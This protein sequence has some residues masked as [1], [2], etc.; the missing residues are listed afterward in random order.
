MKFQINQFK[1]KTFNELP[2]NL[3]K[4]STVGAIMASIAK[5]DPRV[6]IPSITMNLFVRRYG[7]VKL[8]D[9]PS[10]VLKDVKNGVLYVKSVPNKLLESGKE[11]GKT[12]SDAGKIIG[13]RLQQAIT[14]LVADKSL[15]DTIDE[16]HNSE[17]KKL[18][19]DIT[20][21][22]KAIWNDPSW[23]DPTGDTTLLRNVYYNT[24]PLNTLS[25]TIS[26]GLNSITE[27]ESMSL[28]A[29][30][31][32]RLIQDFFISLGS[33]VPSGFT[34]SKI[35]EYVIKSA[36]LYGLVLWLHKSQNCKNV[37]FN[38]RNYSKLLTGSWTR[39]PLAGIY[40]ETDESLNHDTMWIRGG[41]NI[42]LPVVEDHESWSQFNNI[43]NAQWADMIQ[44]VRSVVY[45]PTPIASLLKHLLTT[46][47]A[48]FDDER[49]NELV[50]FVPFSFDSRQTT[51]TV[52]DKITSAYNTLSQYITNY[53][54]LVPIL[55]LLGWQQPLA[56]EDYTRDLH[57]TTFTIS[58]DPLLLT[59]LL[60]TP[61]IYQQNKF[62][63]EEQ[64]TENDNYLT[65]KAQ[66][67]LFNEEVSQTLALG[68]I[69]EF[70]KFVL[71]GD[72]VRLINVIIYQN[73]IDS[74]DVKTAFRNAV[75]YQ[76]LKTSYPSEEDVLPLFSNDDALRNICK[77]FA[78]ASYDHDP[79]LP[80]YFKVYQSITEIDTSGAPETGAHKFR[81]YAKRAWEGDVFVIPD[82]EYLATKLRSY[83]WSGMTDYQI[84]HL[85]SLIVPSRLSTSKV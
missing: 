58:R 5:R 21:R 68:M 25:H 56:N 34:G 8:K 6:A 15:S 18:K 53:Q 1:T 84:S 51:G 14:K 81:T 42:G 62:M 75:L 11:T 9:V 20:A 3:R 83:L 29:T 44:K 72:D 50:N 69:G 38:G 73:D 48:I 17:V 23:Y 7:D 57:G 80:Q 60:N 24:K 76:D 37:V 27:I 10:A 79:I 55:S 78:K 2:S 26:L 63:H 67:T 45:L 70:K 16:Y 40:R 12:L 54:Y 31:L 66:N 39:L 61:S 65:F 43:S 59:A 32:T 35:V 22:W 77:G 13:S 82:Y 47:F 4:A 30:N 28:L 49:E 36:Q 52:L 74:F 64:G 19:E 85:Q 71:L 41:S 33:E 46:S